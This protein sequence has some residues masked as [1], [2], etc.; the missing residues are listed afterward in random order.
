[1]K[2]QLEQTGHVLCNAYVMALLL[3]GFNESSIQ[4]NLS[5]DFHKMFFV[6]ETNL[7]SQQYNSFFIPNIKTVN[8][9]IGQKRYIFAMKS[10]SRD[11]Y[12]VR[13]K[14]SELLREKQ[15]C[16][17]TDSQKLRQ[18]DKI[19]SLLYKIETGA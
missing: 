8:F 2:V 18:T 13:T 16:S 6:S 19:V 4:M 10:L 7:R 17:Q 15:R 1:M 9:C 11:S 12:N 3:S 14:F 5:N